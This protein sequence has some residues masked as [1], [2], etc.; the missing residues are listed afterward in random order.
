MSMVERNYPQLTAYMSLAFFAGIRPQELMRL[1]W[2]DIDLS[3][4]EIL[5]TASNSKTGLARIVHISDNLYYWL[6]NIEKRDGKIF[7]FSE[8]SL[9]RWR[10]RIFKICQ[11]ESIQDGARHSYAT[12]HLALH[13]ISETTQEMGHSNTKTLFRHYRGIARNRNQE[14]KSYF[15]ILPQE[16]FST[17]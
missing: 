11:I 8:S 12:Y 10:Q 2:K 13:T 9:K 3:Q 16:Y 7:C 4:K 17:D 14:A 6:K 5:V 1:E 15:S